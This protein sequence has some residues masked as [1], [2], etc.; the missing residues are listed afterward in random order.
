MKR[1]PLANFLA[2]RMENPQDR[3]SLKEALRTSQIFSEVLEPAPSWLLAWAPLPESEEHRVPGLFVFEG[4]DHLSR[5]LGPEGSQ[6]LLRLLEEKP[7]DLAQVP[8]DFGLLRF[9]PSGSVVAVRSVGGLVPVYYAERPEGFWLASRLHDLLRFLPHLPPLDPLPN[10][11]WIAGWTAFPEGRTFF[12]GIRLLPQGHVLRFTPGSGIHLQRYWDPRPTTLRYPSRQHREEHAQRFRQIILRH[13]ERDLDPRG[14][15]LLTLSGGVD[16]STLLALAAGVLRR[17]MATWSMVPPPQMPDA[18]WREVTHIR[19]LRDRYGV[20]QAWEE[21]LTEEGLPRFWRQGPRLAFHVVHP[22]LCALPR[23]HRQRPVRVLLGG[24]FADHVAGQV[25]TYP[26][27]AHQ[28]SLWQLLRALPE[29]RRTPREILL[30]ARLRARFLR[31]KPPLPLPEF[32]L[33]RAPTGEPMEIFDPRVREEFR[34]W[35]HLL[36]STLLQDPK[37]WR[38][39][40]LEI[41]LSEGF[42][43]MN[44]EVASRFGIRR[45]F[46]FFQREVF[47]LVFSLHP[48]ELV[49]GGMKKLLRRAFHGDVPATHLYRSDK[50]GWARPL[51]SRVL[52]RSFAP[53]LSTLPE[54]WQGLLPS[55]WFP[56]PPRS[57]SYWAYRA[58]VRM[59]IFWQGVERVRQRAG[60]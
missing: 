40:F 57:L 25:F 51:V 10:A 19:S 42:V 32:L 31:R 17:P 11:L 37:P 22:A 23:V 13:L 46:P 50:G 45:S 59:Q 49:G 18:H 48:Q 1:P 47:E 35:V 26:D 8:G 38:Y 58:L 24:E 7:Q 28:L 16:S 33:E 12:Q 44:W 9:Q 5:S 34:E 55:Q 27:W 39:L 43:V 41:Q 21:P 4:G 3:Q 54:A 53:P 30:W 14:G 36:R 20:V 52:H 29:L 15:N 56:R 60:N 6:T 2:V